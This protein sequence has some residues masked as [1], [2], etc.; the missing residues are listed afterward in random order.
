MVGSLNAT[1][2]YCPTLTEDRW[3]IL[4]AVGVYC[5]LVFVEYLRLVLLSAVPVSRMRAVW[6]LGVVPHLEVVPPVAEEGAKK[7]Q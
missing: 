7:E 6:T 1:P 5:Y 3:H 4:T 2:A